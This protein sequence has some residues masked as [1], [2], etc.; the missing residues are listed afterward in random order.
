MAQIRAPFPAAFEG[1]ERV[2]VLRFNGKLPMAGIRVQDVLHIL[3][4][5]PHFGDLSDHGS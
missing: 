1:E 3:W 2:M 4:I 5:G